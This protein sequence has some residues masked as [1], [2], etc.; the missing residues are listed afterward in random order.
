[1]AVQEAEAPYRA[2]LEGLEV[3]DVQP[4]TQTEEQQRD[5]MMDRNQVGEVVHQVSLRKLKHD[6]DQRV[7]LVGNSHPCRVAL[8]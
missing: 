7:P 5:Q 6:A 1:M 4:V 3:A 2:R 8:V